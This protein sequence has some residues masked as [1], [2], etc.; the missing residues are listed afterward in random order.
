M[1]PAAAQ[2][3]A[4][5]VALPPRPQITER[6]ASSDSIDGCLSPKQSKPQTLSPP[7]RS[8]TG[9]PR[10]G[11][12]FDGGADLGSVGKPHSTQD[13]II[14]PVRTPSPPFPLPTDLKTL[15]A[16]MPL[17]EAPLTLFPS[18]PILSFPPFQPAPRAQASTSSSLP[19]PPPS[20]PPSKK[21][22]DSADIPRFWF[23]QATPP[24]W[25]AQCQQE[26]AQMASLTSQHPVILLSPR[27]LSC[28]FLS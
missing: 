20:A 21:R 1:L 4:H 26:R 16:I 7:P 9:K 10:P 12:S 2:R 5:P 27:L 3:H 15:H 8:P 17:H 6:M 18:P 25:A 14:D 13:M 19:S 11:S 24:P 28:V 22:A 23:P